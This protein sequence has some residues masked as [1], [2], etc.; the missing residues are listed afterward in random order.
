VP[1][2]DRTPPPAPLP[3]PADAEVRI[4]PLAQGDLAEVVRIHEL[5]TGVREPDYWEAVLRRVRLEGEAREV[6]LAAET[7]GGLA[8]FLFGEVRAFEFGSDP[9]GWLFAVGVDPRFARG[10]TASR[11]L[12]EACRC[13]HAMGVDRVRT[14]VRRNDVPL[15]AFFRANGFAGGAFVQ[16]ERSLDEGDPA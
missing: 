8:A 5:H 12:D 16:L 7:D 9:C 2:P 6:A 10:G 4:R 15:L 14:M 13:F 3:A 11:L 1:G